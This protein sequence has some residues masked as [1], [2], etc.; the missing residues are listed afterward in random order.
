MKWIKK[1][2]I[3]QATGEYGWIN[4]HAQIPTVLVKDNCLRVY[5]SPRPK[6]GLSCIAMMDID[7]NNP[8]KILKLYDTPVLT[9]GQP[10]DFDEHGIMPQWVTEKDNKV[11]L[12]Y[13]GWSRRETIPYSNWEGLAI[14]YDGGLTFEKC[15]KG[16]ILDRTRD[17]I[18]SGTGLFC[19]ES[20]N[21]YYGFY[22]N[23]TKWYNINGKQESAYEIVTTQSKDLIT[24]ENRNGKP[25]LMKKTAEE[26]NTRP[27]VV[28]IGGRYHMWFCY[29]GVRDYRDG[30]D[31]YSIGYAYSDDLITWVRDDE[32]AG[33]SKSETGWDSKMMAY[34]Y[35]VQVDERFYMFYNGNYFGKAGFGYAEL[36]L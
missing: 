7:R 13:A 18:L 27:T 25:I 26:A 4:S 22:A 31:S 5:F 10:G 3:F 32:K 33:I 8:K 21:Q 12:I 14:S 16:P 20:N 2:M 30:I 29:R 36:D 11:Y 6:E 1:G 23:G 15:F 35:V 9:H 28:K 24:W 19:V 34:P 17:E